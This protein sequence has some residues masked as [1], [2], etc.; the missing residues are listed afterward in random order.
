MLSLTAIVRPAS[1]PSPVVWMLVVVPRAQRVVRVGRPLPLAVGRLRQARR[2]P[3][4]DLVV[5]AQQRVSEGAEGCDVLA[6]DRQAVGGGDPG[7]VI[8]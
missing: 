2:V 7:D 8:V 1:G 6:R 4:L 5:R 3:P